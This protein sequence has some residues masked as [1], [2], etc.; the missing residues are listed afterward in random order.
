VTTDSRVEAAWDAAFPGLPECMTL[1]ESK[2]RIARAVAALDAYDR[3]H[4]NDGCCGGTCGMPP[5]SEGDRE[6]DLRER[7]AQEISRIPAVIQSNVGA[8]V[9]RDD[10]ARIARGQS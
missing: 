2:R 10:A 6:A 9:Y 1:E 8:L 7:I 3:E 4:R 5:C